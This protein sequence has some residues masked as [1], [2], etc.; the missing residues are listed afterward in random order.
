MS[1]KESAMLIF[2]V[3]KLMNDDIVMVV[4]TTMNMTMICVVLLTFFNSYLVL[5]RV[6]SM[7]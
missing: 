2:M 3:T 1:Q 7:K 6:K 4:T 5:K